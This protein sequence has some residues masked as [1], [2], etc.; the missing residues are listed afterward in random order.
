M[1]GGSHART[2]Y[3]P[4]QAKPSIWT[5]TD[6]TSEREMVAPLWS[7]DPGEW[8][9]QSR[10]TKSTKGGNWFF[11]FLNLIELLLG[12]FDLICFVLFC[13]F[14]SMPCRLWGLFPRKFL[15]ALEGASL[16]FSI[17]FLWF[18][19]Y[20][21]RFSTFHKEVFVCC[22]FLLCV[23]TWGGNLFLWGGGGGGG[24]MKNFLV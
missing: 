22:C 6:V 16:W 1:N 2:T 20:L 12:P 8:S 14:R 23:W 3:V 11:I 10:S 5:S 21:V 24:A 4:G 18:W 17:D 13:F 15:V 19:P 9:R 7:H